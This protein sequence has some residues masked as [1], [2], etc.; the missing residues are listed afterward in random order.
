MIGPAARRPGQGARD[1]RRRRRPAAAG[2]LRP[3]LR[4]RRRAADADPG[5]G[6]GADPAVGV[7]VRAAGAGARLVRGVAPPGLRHGRAGRVGRPGDARAAAGDAA[8]RV[9]GPRLPVRLGDGRS[10]RRTGSIRDVA[11][12]PGLVE[13]SRLPAPVFTP[14]TKAEVGEHDEAIDF[15]AVVDRRRCC[16]A[17]AELRDLTLALYGAGA[18][19]RG[20]GRASSSPT[21]SSSSACRRRRARLVLGDEVLTPDSSRFWPARPWSPGAAQ[22]SYDKQFVRDWLT[23]SGWDRVSPAAGAAGRRRRRHPRALRH[24]LRAAHR[25]EVRLMRRTRGGI[26]YASGGSDGPLLLLLHGLGATGAVW[27][28]LLA[29][30]QDA[31]ARPVGGA[32]PPG[33]RAVA[34]RGP[35][36]VRGARRGHGRARGRAEAPSV[37]VLGP[38]VRRRRRRGAGQRLVRRDRR[39]RGRARREDRLDRRRDLPRPGDVP[40]SAAGVRRA[41]A[42]PRTGTSSWPDCAISSTRPSRSPGQASRSSTAAGSPRWTRARSAPSG[43]RWRRRCRACAAPLRLAAGSADPMVG[44]DAMRRVDPDAVLRRRRR[45]QRPLGVPRQGL[46]AA[47]VGLRGECDELGAITR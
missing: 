43:R 17:P 25:P 6:P 37:T 42:R 4:L 34:E 24:R 31:V 10:T 13:G 46:A 36:R 1:L 29:Q 40:P 33:A 8:G 28:R 30:F 12:P 11:L 35:L 27:T 7:V 32:R 21:P 20:R 5:Q 9:R 38:L 26:A 23:S 41:P 45:P 22:P 47:P 18:R 3:D 15:A 44:L 19:D 2:R 14:S 16:R 39:P